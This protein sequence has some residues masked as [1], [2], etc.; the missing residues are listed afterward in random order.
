MIFNKIEELRRKNG[1]TQE[2]LAKIVGF[3]SD[4]LR[5]SLKTNKLPLCALEGLA[6]Y[7]NVPVSYFFDNGPTIHQKNDMRHSEISDSTFGT[8]SVTYNDV[9]AFLEMQKGMQLPC[10]KKEAHMDRVFADLEQAVL[11]KDEQLRNKDAQIAAKD[12][13]ISALQ[14]T[15]K[16]LQRQ[17]DVLIEKCLTKN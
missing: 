17:M 16:N 7:F 10:N 3:T 9:A 2:E 13:Q 12:A 4:G 8:G 15:I 11:A 5:N 14:E 1:I 6:Q